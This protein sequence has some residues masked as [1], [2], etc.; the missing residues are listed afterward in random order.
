MHLL[1]KQL[2]ALKFVFFYKKD[3]LSVYPFY[4][5]MLYFIVPIILS[6]SFVLVDTGDSCT[7]KTTVTIT[8]SKIIS[9]THSLNGYYNR[10][11]KKIFLCPQI[12]AD[13]ELARHTYI[14]EYGHYLWDTLSKEKQ[15]EWSNLSGEKN[16]VS[17]YSEKDI[18]EDFAETF[19]YFLL[20]ME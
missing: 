15:L 11:T 9:H 19:A 16:Y 5:S 1:G 17:K 7:P 3:M 14:H 6:A 12:L 2:Q 13:K 4:K 8:E 20:K 10:E 18:Y